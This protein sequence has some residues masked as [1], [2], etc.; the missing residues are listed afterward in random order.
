MAVA[1]NILTVLYA[2]N[3]GFR[4]LAK[5]MT[6][7]VQLLLTILSSHIWDPYIGWSSYFLLRSYSILY[8]PPLVYGNCIN[9]CF[10]FA[11]LSNDN[12]RFQWFKFYFGTRAYSF[13]F[14][15]AA[16]LRHLT[17]KTL[18][19]SVIIFSK[20][21]QPI[22]TLEMKGRQVTNTHSNGLT[23]FMG[24]YVCGSVG[25]IRHLLAQVS[26]SSAIPE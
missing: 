3:S 18:K 12:L 17:T 8:L 16:L 20:I 13:F 15:F 10:I 22:L 11:V 14:F 24:T 1:P 6:A 2:I 19:A 7:K 23:P 9:V 26:R 25:S 5:G 21:Q 4:P